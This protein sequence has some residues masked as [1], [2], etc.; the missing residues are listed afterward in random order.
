MAGKNG[1][2]DLTI[3]GISDFELLG[4]VDDLADEEGWTYT[5]EV[6][7]Q[8]GESLDKGYR[9]GVGSRLGWMRRYGWLESK[10]TGSRS[11]PKAFRLTTVG[12]TLLDNPNLSG[13]FERTFKG[14]NPAQ[15]L[16]LTRELA[17]GAAGG[18]EEIHSALRRQ[19]TRSMRR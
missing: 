10:G 1:H 16:I 14:L 17:E 19:W 15:R 6:R 8:L 7:L 13:A 2:I 18:V 9:S 5:T 11:D 3:W 4:V 12:H